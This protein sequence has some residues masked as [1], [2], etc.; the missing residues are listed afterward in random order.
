[1]RA[2]GMG[3]LG[4]LRN[5]TCWVRPFRSWHETETRRRLSAAG[6]S[7]TMHE[8]E[9]RRRLSLAAVLA[10]ELA[11]RRASGTSAQYVWQCAGQARGE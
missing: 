4:A 3:P 2:S 9:T 6:L 11:T 10:A 7:Q 1:M 8:T 5:V